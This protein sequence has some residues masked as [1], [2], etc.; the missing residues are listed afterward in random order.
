MTKMEE[1]VE[2]IIK[3]LSEIKG[4]ENDIPDSHSAIKMFNKK[5]FKPLN[6]IAAINLVNG[7][8]DLQ[9]HIIVAIE[10]HNKIS[11]LS[12]EERKE[13]AEHISVLKGWINGILDDAYKAAT[14]SKS[15]KEMTREELIE[16]LKK[17]KG[18]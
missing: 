17:A 1:V 5:N 18:K 6:Q 14:A 8:I 12:N 13:L 16:E 9:N 2:K 11:N 3:E 15:Y 10:C 7:I 4:N